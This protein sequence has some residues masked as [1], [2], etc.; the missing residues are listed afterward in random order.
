MKK[1]L[2]GTTAIVGTTV[3]LGVP[4]WAAEKPKLQMDG[5]MRFEAWNVSQDDNVLGSTSDTRNRGVYFDMDDVEIHFFGS[6]KADNGLEFG[7][8]AE[9]IEGSGDSAGNIGFD[10]TNVFLGGGWGKLVLGAN[11]GPENDMDVGAYSVMA[12]KD[13]AWDGEKP[14]STYSNAA[15][16][17]TDL[18]PS[19]GQTGD[20]N[21][22]VYY[23]PVFSGF[24]VGASYTPDNS[25]SENAGLDDEDAGELENAF[26]VAAKYSGTFSDVNVQVSARY[27]RSGYQANDNVLGT[28]Q[29]NDVSAYGFGAVIGYAGFQVGGSYTDHG[30]SGITEANEALGIDAGKWWDIGVSYATGPY[31]VS[32]AYM[33]SQAAQGTGTDDDEV[34][35]ISIGAGWAVSPGLDLYASYQHVELDRT[36]TT[37]DA[38][39]DLFLIGTMVSF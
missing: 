32:A 34:D 22:I 9:I 11:D 14:F 12:D 31:K 17:G 21:K 15:Y 27:L 20:A 3:L 29:R 16:L 19:G 2:L 6:T 38:D 28:S 7:F 23:T 26:S 18:G 37:S 8:Y 39:A 13:G 5:W 24:Q 35:Y 1:I 36:G 4:T 25:Q 33:N 30:D 10:E